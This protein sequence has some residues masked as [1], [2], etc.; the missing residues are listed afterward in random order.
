MSP[1]AG[2]LAGIGLAM[3]LLLVLG[4]AGGVW[5]AANHY[6]PLLDT[7]NADLAKAKMARDNLEELAGEQD[8]K[9][10]ELVAAGELRERNAVQA[11]AKAKEGASTDYAAANR[12]MQERTG[13]DP[14]ETAASIIDQEL[15]L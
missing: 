8:R 13:G 5:L 2:K 11:I 4:A 14:A 7:A 6:R 9:L 10:G 12:L 1:A 3:T 15:G